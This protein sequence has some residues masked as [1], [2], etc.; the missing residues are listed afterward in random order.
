MYNRNPY[1]VSLKQIKKEDNND[2][3]KI[4]TKLFLYYEL[5]PY[6]LQYAKEGPVDLEVSINKF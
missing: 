4:G 3:L 5:V 6:S 1:V 2:P